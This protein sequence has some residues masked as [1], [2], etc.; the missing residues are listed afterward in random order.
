MGA[1]GR[2]L[3][4]VAAIRSEVALKVLIGVAISAT[5]IG[6][7]LV[8]AKAVSVVF[9]GGSVADI[10]RY[11]VIALMAVFLRGYLTRVMES[12]SKVM[13][14]KVKNKIRLTIFDKILR[15]GPSYLNNKRSGRVQSLVLDGIESLEPFLVYYVPQII[16]ISITGLAIGIYLT[17]LDWVTGAII[18]VAMLLCVIV[19]YLTVPL[20]SR[21]IVTYWSSY[22]MLN[23]QYVDAMQGMTTLQ[24]FK[25]SRVK[26]VELA[27][28]ALAFYRQAIR[29]TTFSL[30]DSGLMMIL[31]SIAASITVAIAA[32][33]TDIGIIPIIAVS[34]FLFL[35]VECAR[36]MADLNNYWHNSFLGLSVAK[37]LFEIV[38]KN[39]EIIEKE[40]P[41]RTSLDLGLPSV[42][43]SEVIFA[44][45]GGGKP[46]INNVTL[47]IKAGETVALVGRS[48][49]GKSTIVNLLLRFYDPSQGKILING[50]DIKDYSIEYLQ[51][52]IAVVF[53]DTYLFQGTIAENLRMARP[54]ADDNTVM[55]AAKSAGAHDFIMALSDGYQTIIGER[56]ATL[57]GGEKQRL[58]I[59]RAILKDAPLLILDEAT[60]NVD[61]KSEALIQKTLESLTRNR[62][63]II[64]AHRLSTIQH[65]D[66]IYVLDESN[67]AETGT[68]HELLQLKGVYADLVDAQRRGDG[69]E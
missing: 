4:Y 68:H 39:L 20:V 69:H 46:A 43:F 36:P 55:A 12:Y 16:T 13:A 48:G 60:S 42:H 2:L 67:L 50:V 66:K 26:G 3:R 53:Q 14:A 61:A 15:L 54:D 34:A 49:S 11:L 52:K 30:I 29:N 65:A 41:D 37:E 44:Y 64:I 21:S 45:H 22:A 62:T 17:L 38:D 33:R 1:Y 56:G 47:D 28:N 24:A 63:T 27:D 5:Y 58:A 51:S 59:A 35:A 18:I 8:M 19:P 6:Q 7:A 9:V 40:E 25:A 10:S 31:T 23:A 57:S 32:F